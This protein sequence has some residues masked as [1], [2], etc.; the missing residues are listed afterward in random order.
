MKKAA[1]QIGERRNDALSNRKTN[2]SRY[3]SDLFIMASRDDV[4][5]KVF[6]SFH[7]L[8]L[9]SSPLNECEAVSFVVR[10]FLFRDIYGRVA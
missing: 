2:P 8:L 7:A 10:Q 5:N 1:L 6:C 3:G 4:Y 9:A